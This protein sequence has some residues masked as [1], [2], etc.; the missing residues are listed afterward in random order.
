MADPC[1]VIG[2]PALGSTVEVRACT[3]RAVRIRYFG[4]PVV[5][6][7]A[8]VER[9][10]WP[11]VSQVAPPRRLAETGQI[12]ST[13][14]LMVQVDDIGPLPLLAVYDAV[15]RRL[16][17]T[18][19]VG[20][21]VREEAEDAATGQRRGRV[22]VQLQRS[23]TSYDDDVHFYGLGQ[24]GGMQLDRLGTSRL[25]WNSQ[26]GHASGVDFG[27]PL[28]VASGPAGAYGLFFDTTA[29]ARLDTAR[30]SGGLTLRYEAESPSVDVYILAG[31][32]PADVLEAYA[33]LTGFPSM[34][35]RWA[36]GFLQSTRFFKQTDDILDLARTMRAK[37]LPCDALIFL[38][39]Y[40]TSMGWNAGVGHVGFHE[41][42]WS[43]PA[44]TLGVLQD[45][46][47]FRTVTHEY[48]VLHPD[49]PQCAEAEERGFLLGV[50]YPAPESLPTPTDQREA[51]HLAQRYHENQRFIDFTNPAARVW[52]WE[53]HRHL[54][55]LGIAGWWLDGGEGPSGPAPLHRGDSTLMHNAFDLYRFR[56]FAEGEWR[57]RPDGRPW[58]LCRSGAAGMQRFGAGSWTGDINTTFTTFATQPL[59]GLGLAMSGVP[60]WGTDIGG[61]YPNALNGELYAR[62]FQFGTFSPIFRAH[63]WEVERHLP[64]AHGPEVEAICKKYLELRMRLLPY[65][66]TLAWQAHTRGQPIMR[67]L[68]FHYPADPNVWELGSQYLF[69]PDLLVAPVTQAG[70]THWSVYLPAGDWYDF[71]TGERH[72]GGRAISVAVP[73]DTLPLFVRGGSIVPLGPSMQRTDE[74]PLDNLTILVYPGAP[75]ASGTCAIY[76]DDGATQAHQRG[77][78]ALTTVTS[79]FGDGAARVEVG[80]TT[81]TYAGQPTR[82]DLTVRLWRESRPGSVA[83]RRSAVE[84]RTVSEGDGA[85]SSD[86]S[87]TWEA[88]SWVTVRVPL[89]D[90]RSSLTVEVLG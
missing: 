29:M 65:I 40:G 34:P 62:W 81:G 87:W 13:G 24:G 73:L 42:L 27:V 67:P 11:A 64:W 12:I 28:L 6:E 72:A 3:P 84:A 4:A 83:V 89:A 57:D 9:T 16:L 38:S 75:G 48:P 45:D 51:T 49:A 63:G 85:G 46:L 39:T 59:L 68:A 5:A 77:E 61:F 90:V 2:M 30:G 56:A 60:Y 80:A 66:Y 41:T 79:T 25:F 58:M 35:P 32:T 31:P 26:V 69:G 19:A 36:L 15:G 18:P 10:E 17:G 8:Y 20:S 14:H 47:G 52:W 43:D 23:R 7:A 86:A 37:E 78:S 21:L 70:A 74:R 33:E 1:P 88:P 76:E 53:Q 71:W 50:A 22:V 82:R 54:V 44:A 55:E